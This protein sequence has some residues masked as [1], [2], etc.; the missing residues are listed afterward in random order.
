MDFYHAAWDFGEVRIA[1][2]L[3]TWIYYRDSTLTFATDK[4]SGSKKGKDR[5]TALVAVNMDGSDK[6]PLL[7]IG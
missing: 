1:E 5:I 4:L 7:I 2:H 6:C 3:Q